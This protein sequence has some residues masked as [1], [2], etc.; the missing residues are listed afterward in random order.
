MIVKETLSYVKKYQMFKDGEKIV[1]GLSGG[2]D[3]ICLCSILLEFRKIMDI[4]LVAVHVHHGLRGTDADADMAYVQTFCKENSVLCRTFHVDIAAFAK[5][6]GYSEEEAGRIYRYQCFENVRQSEHAQHIAVAHHQG[7]QAETVLFNLFRG[8]GL[9]G[10]CGISP[11]RGYIIRPILWME[12]KQIQKYVDNQHLFY[13]TDETNAIDTYSRNKIRLNILPYVEEN[14]NEG[15]GQHIARCAEKLREVW[16]YM[17]A[18]TERA[19]ETYVKKEDAGYLIKLELFSKE[20]LVIQKEV[21]KKTL[22]EAAGR[23]KDIE[24]IHI[25]AVVALNGLQSGK[26]IDLPYALNAQKRYKDIRISKRESIE[27]D[28]QCHENISLDKFPIALDWKTMHIELEKEK[29]D[30]KNDL[31][32]TKFTKNRC[33]K[34]FDYDKI[35]VGLALRTRQNGDFITLADG[36]KKKLSRFMID[37]KIPKD[38]RDKILL[39]ADGEHIL[40]VIDY[41]ISEM[42]KVTSQT[43]TILK[44]RIRGE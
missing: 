27:K 9:K 12:R 41:R 11:V 2:A 20:H 8:S 38:Q 22:G 5:A 23:L 19:Y 31:T 44:V 21:I 13:C 32:H 37:E 17:A 25:E 43:K 29:I 16:D 6:N 39:L 28:V 33:T 10:V 40:W 42:Y 14:I 3:S 24:S 36:N 26:E 34:W 15:A 18:E 4:E 7:D 35:K 30:E 1:I